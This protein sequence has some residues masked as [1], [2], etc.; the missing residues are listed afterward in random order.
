MS[1]DTHLTQSIA[2]ECHVEIPTSGNQIVT[3]PI[4]DIV[5]LENREPAI[6]FLFVQ[7]ERFRISRETADQIRT[8]INKIRPILSLEAKE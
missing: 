7:G 5:L 6:P 1:F 3:M 4:K 8:L 2:H